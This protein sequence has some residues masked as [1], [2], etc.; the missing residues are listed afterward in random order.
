MQSFDY[1]C[2][3]FRSAYMFFCIDVRSSVV[4]DHPECKGPE[5]IKELAKKWAVCTDREKYQEQALEDKRRYKLVSQ[6]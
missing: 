1:E 4:A 3:P 2:L 5:V 6:S